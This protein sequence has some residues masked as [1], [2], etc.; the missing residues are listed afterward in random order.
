MSLRP[1]RIAFESTMPSLHSQITQLFS[2]MQG[3]AAFMDPFQAVYDLCTAYPK[4]FDDALFES[5]SLFI[6]EYA[7]EKRESIAGSLDTVSAYS[8][9]W[10]HFTHASRY[11]DSVCEYLNRI[12]AKKRS[13]M[14]TQ[15]RRRLNANGSLAFLIWKETV[16]M[17]IKSNAGNRLLNQIFDFVKRDRDG[18]PLVD[19]GVI[20]NTVESFVQICEFVPQPLQF[21]IQEFEQPYIQSTREYYIA[22]SNTL[23]STM[24]ISE[25]MKCISKRI[26]DEEERSCRFCNE[27][28]REKVIKE[29]VSQCVT[30]HKERLY[31]AFAA[32]LRDENLGDCTL[33][34]QLMLK[35]P[36]GILPMLQLFQKHMFDLGKDIVA[37]LRPPAQKDPRDFIHGLIDLHGKWS[38]ICEKTF[39]NNTAFGAA[40]DKGFRQIVNES[41]EKAAQNFPEL[42]SRF[43]DS[44]LKKTLK[45]QW[46]EAE[47][48][49][50]IGKA[51]E[52]HYVFQKFYSR[53]LG[54]RLLGN[55]SASDDL[56]MAMISGL[57]NVCGVEYT[58]KLQRMFTDITLSQ[59]LNKR[60]STSMQRQN[61]N[62]GVDFSILVL[63]AGS[64]PSMPGAI[65]YDVPEE[66][67]KSVTRFGDFYGNNHNGRKL[68]WMYHLCKADV[69]LTYLDKKYELNLSLHQLSVLLPFNQDTMLTL[70]SIVDRVKIKLAD[71]RKIIKPLID[72]EVLVATNTQLDD[73]TE[74]SVNMKFSNKRTKLKV[75]AAAQNE[76]TSTQE[77]EV[78]RAAVDED[79][80]LYLQA[81][82]VRILKSRRVMGHNQLIQEV[83]QLSTSR[84]IPSIALIKKSVE[85][86]IDKGYMERSKERP[87]QYVYVA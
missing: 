46:T 8:R 82:I 44:L 55:L 79:R 57:K 11:L 25:Y 29:C 31:D 77:S 47:L 27:T 33:V 85:Q 36:G 5:L 65:D 76:S 83:I 80:K 54:R 56:E 16:L 78:T 41:Y 50:K 20:I 64:W 10:T 86:L 62:L 40:L 32:M 6:A 87:D 38:A 72:L 43:A 37:R 15:S 35:I 68:S 21:Y 34:Y 70:G 1:K 12:T 4:P 51:V 30:A 73:S 69:K 13:T 61:V 49:D 22:E 67:L 24:T 74:I 14:P 2:P 81:T 28:S 19:N 58:S 39:S 63:T 60:F 53:M 59:D 52:L 42:L 75:S 45:S 7:R 48:E 3:D 17:E 71:V 26:S 9:E 23:I 66:L 84:F 18:T